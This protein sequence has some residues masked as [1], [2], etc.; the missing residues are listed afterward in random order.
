MDA[1]GWQDL[2]SR[3]RDHLVAERGLA[4]LSVRNYLTDLEPLREFMSEREIES[5]AELDRLRVRAYLAW[6]QQIGYVRASV[7]RK[8]SALRNLFKW[9]NS[10]GVVTHDPL[11]QRGAV[12]S[13]SR[14][15]RFL[16]EN[17]AAK[18]M[19]SP[20]PS[21]KKRIRDKALLELVYAT[22]LR[23]SEVGSLNLDSINLGTCEL[24]VTGKGSKDRVVLMGQ[25]A[26]DAVKIYLSEVRTTAAAVEPEDALFVNR[27]GG[28]LSVR[29]IQKIVREYA[30]RAGIAG[31]VHTH[32]L[33]HSFATHMFNGGA[34][35]RAVQELLGH[36][37]P[38]TTQI[39]THIT[40]KE[41][42]QAYMSAHPRAG[43]GPAPTVNEQDEGADGEDTDSQRPEPQQSRQA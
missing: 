42:R 27:S 26:R 39:Y 31:N 28:R 32:T 13:E 22:G 35:I 25:S 37:N 43:S 20:D 21:S 34:D 41:A 3:F 6:L 10:V 36:S 2:T 29:S 33:R 17:E 16:S 38:G 14:L 24:T 15:P 1:A 30:T 23:V 18:L 11:P 19:D 40:G 12:K 7:I 4:P 5:F 9:L 8:L